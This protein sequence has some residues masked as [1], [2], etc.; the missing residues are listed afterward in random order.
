MARPR[1]QSSADALKE[2]H[3]VSLKGT[4]AP[5][6]ALS[7]ADQGQYCGKLSG[8]NMNGRLSDPVGYLDRHYPTSILCL[9]PIRRSRAERL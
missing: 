3:A 9:R 4:P 1:A 5:L 8:Q 6:G 2:P 7:L